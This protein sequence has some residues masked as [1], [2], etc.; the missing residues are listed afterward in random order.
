MR[1]KWKIEYLTNNIDCPYQI[2]SLSD[3]FPNS[4]VLSDTTK[5]DPY[6]GISIK[7]FFIFYFFTK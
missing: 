7:N 5:G 4:K 2:I 1:K 3:N 6:N